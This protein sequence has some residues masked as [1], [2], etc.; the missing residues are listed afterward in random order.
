MCSVPHVWPTA[1]DRRNPHRLVLLTYQVPLSMPGLGAWLVRRGFAEK[2]LK[3]GR[4][5]GS[6]TA[7]ELRAYGDVMAEPKAA[8]ATTG[9]YRQFLIKELPGLVKGQYAKQRLQVPTRLLV[10]TEDAAVKGSTLEGA[11]ANDLTV[12]WIEGV[13]HFLPDVD[14]AQIGREPGRAGDAVPAP[15]PKPCST[16]CYAATGGPKQAVSASTSPS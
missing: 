6:W 10:G 9:I 3:A 7:E 8:E 5:R 12:H 14:A 4:A 1:K 13:G 2:L 15:S 16:C 11:N